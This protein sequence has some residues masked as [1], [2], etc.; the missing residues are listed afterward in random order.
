MSWAQSARY[1][2]RCLVNRAQT[3]QKWLIALKVCI[4]HH[5]LLRE[6]RGQYHKHLTD[7]SAAAPAFAQPG[8][9]GVGGGAPYGAGPTGASYA[10][11]PTGVSYGAAPTGA[12]AGGQSAALGNEVAPPLGMRGFRDASSKK[13]F[14]LSTFIRFYSAYLD[15]QADVFAKTKYIPVNIPGVEPP[16]LK[17]A[18]S[19]C[20]HPGCCKPSM[21]VAGAQQA[22]SY[23]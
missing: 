14:D 9:H 12:S 16:K 23:S 13:A 10:A 21:V 6:S 8:L 15:A 20:S 3:L 19:R 17:C 5:R 22:T 7:P 2:N 4:T 1:I 11:G 18:A